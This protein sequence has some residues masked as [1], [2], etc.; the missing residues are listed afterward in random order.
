MPSLSNIFILKRLK[1]ALSQRN[2]QFQKADSS[3]KGFCQGGG[4]RQWQA[5]SKVLSTSESI[6]SA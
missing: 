3:A 1:D 2:R 4:P 6:Y 5:Y